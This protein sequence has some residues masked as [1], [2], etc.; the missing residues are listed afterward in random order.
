MGSASLFGIAVWHVCRRWP[1]P[2]QLNGKFYLVHLFLASLYA[3]LWNL[4]VYGLESVRRGTNELHDFWRSPVLGW[5]LLMGVWL[6]GLFAGV[7]LR[8]SDEES[9]A[10]KGD[11]RSTC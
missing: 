10:R 2:L 8:Y 11:S 6:Y 5:Q 3:L 4:A 7:S 9:S 1:W